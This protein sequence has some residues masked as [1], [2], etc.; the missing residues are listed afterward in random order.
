MVKLIVHCFDIRK[1]SGI[2]NEI[3]NLFTHFVQAIP[4]GRFIIS[5]LISWDFNEYVVLKW[6]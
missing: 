6:Y 2:S 5:K 3:P 4:N 1:A